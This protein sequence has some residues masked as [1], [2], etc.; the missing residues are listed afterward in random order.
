[1]V[2]DRWKKKRH[3]PYTERGISRVLCIRCGSPASFQWQICSD[4]N[5]YRPLCTD[6]DI[7]LNLL[8]LEW[9][10]HPNAQELVAKYKASKND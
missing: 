1:M 4:G 3:A 2:K 8:V 10:G 5:Q 6:C 7:G 9:M